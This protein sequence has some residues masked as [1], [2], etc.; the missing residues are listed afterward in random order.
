L[1]TLTISDKQGNT[2][3]TISLNSQAGKNGVLAF[4]WDG[5]S[6]NGNKM[7]QGLYSVTANYTDASG[8]A[9]KTQFGVYP[10]ESVRYTNGKPLM[11]LGSS[12]VPMASISEFY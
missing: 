6:N 12:Y 7:K 2:V 10:V 4:Q 9:Q 3:R 11:K 8:N 1:R 5:V